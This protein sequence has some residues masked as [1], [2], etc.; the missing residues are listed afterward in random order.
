MRVKICYF[1]VFQ[2]TKRKNANSQLQIWSSLPIYP[3]DSQSLPKVCYIS[4]KNSEILS[5]VEAL[6]RGPKMIYRTGPKITPSFFI[7]ITILPWG[8]A[9]KILTSI[10]FDCVPYTW[11]SRDKV[12]FS[13]VAANRLKTSNLEQ[14]DEYLDR[15]IVKVL[16]STW[17]ASAI[18]SASTQKLGNHWDRKRGWSLFKRWR[19]QLDVEQRPRL[20]VKCLDPWSFS[21]KC[22]DREHLNHN[23]C[24]KWFYE[25]MKM[26]VKGTL[27]KKN[28]ISQEIKSHPRWAAC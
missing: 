20:E 28:K 4:W 19:W 26:Q 18:Y 14:C 22:Q 27:T 3:N 25:G 12:G 6:V 16:S 24:K 13:F 21:V 11:L 23:L 17:N 2:P 5:R 15:F 10:A 7:Q 9:D 8:G 1:V